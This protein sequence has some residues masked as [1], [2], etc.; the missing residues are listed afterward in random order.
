MDKHGYSILHQSK[1]FKARLG[2][3]ASKETFRAALEEYS[4]FRVDNLLS[5]AD[6][7]RGAEILDF[8]IQSQTELNT[9]YY[10]A[11]KAACD[12]LKNMCVEA[13]EDSD[14][15][16]SSVSPGFN[17]SVISKDYNNLNA[18]AEKLLIAQARAKEKEKGSEPKVQV[19]NTTQSA[20]NVSAIK[21]EKAEAINFSGLARDYARFRREFV[22]IVVPNR[23]ETEVGLRL[24]QAVPKE[25]RHLLDNID[26]EN[27]KQML[28]ILDKNFGTADRVV[29]SIMGEVYK[30]KSPGDDKAF[31][32]FVEKLE[33]AAR[34][35]EAV[36][37]LGEIVNQPT[38]ASI[39]EKFTGMIKY[40]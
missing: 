22:M 39:T 33:A 2:L 38:I 9:K 6:K 12:A 13:N 27:F 3:T 31:V 10:L 21:L 14:T 20:S 4:N 32:T 29:N 25:H 28:E 11:L 19:N 24:R 23:S 35:L 7:A 1:V 34:D 8:P 16:L 17:L 40:G 36:N 26:L 37:L 15:V 18:G 30:L 5:Q